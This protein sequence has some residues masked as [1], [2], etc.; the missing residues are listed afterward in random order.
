[1]CFLAVFS[2]HFFGGRAYLLARA[3][4]GPDREERER[5]RERESLPEALGRGA[6]RGMGA[7]F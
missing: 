4:A 1:M 6:R 7:V 5:E 2:P 3:A